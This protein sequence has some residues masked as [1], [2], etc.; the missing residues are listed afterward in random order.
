V[1][2]GDLS[3]ESRPHPLRRVPAQPV[4]LIG[5]Q[6]ELE[7]IR[8]LLLRPNVRLVTLSGPGG[9]GK[10]RLALA[11]AEDMADRFDQGVTFVD[12]SSLREARK[13]LPAVA[14]ALALYE[15]GARPVRDLLERA[16]A[17]RELLLVL[18]N[19]EHLLAAAAELSGLLE[20][21]LQLRILVTSRE[22]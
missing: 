11:V 18:D 17:D 13:V 7:A 21:C 6:V 1:P 15:G 20:A 16:I 10:T 14:R 9:V 19:F 2:T 8:T 5:R 22:P 4:S 3:V 12:L